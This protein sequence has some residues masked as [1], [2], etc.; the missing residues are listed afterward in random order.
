LD[1]IVVLTQKELKVRYRNSFLGYLWSIANPLAYAFI[2]YVAFKV[3]MR[4]PMEDYTLFLIAGLFPWQ[5]FSNSVTVSTMAFLSNASIIK[6]VSFP[7]ETVVFT[8]VLQDMIHFAISIPVIVIF[9]FVYGKA[10]S[11]AW[12]WG[13]PLLL[14]TQFLLTYGLSLIVASVNLFF[15]D[16]EKFNGLLVSFLF[17]FT[18]IIYPM[19]L[20]PEEYRATL[21]LNPLA[22]LML[23]WR[24][25]FLGEPLLFARVGLSALFAF[26]ALG[27][28]YVVYRRL[29][30]RFAEVL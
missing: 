30:W 29:S 10:P 24:D 14:L 22:P 1:L 9:L 8:T 26:V 21:I 12:L 25:L 7:R 6:K 23:S 3:V 11:T 27:L 16:M 19:S 5:W 13:I 4:M 17:Y 20:V 28:G 15:R 18:P 2:F